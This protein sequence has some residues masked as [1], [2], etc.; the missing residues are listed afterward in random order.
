MLDMS[1]PRIPAQITSKL[2]SEYSSKGS[3]RRR[4]GSGDSTEFCGS[5]V[6]FAHHRSKRSIFKGIR[7]ISRKSHGSNSFIH[8]LGHYFI[9]AHISKVSQN[10]SFLVLQAYNLTFPLRHMHFIPVSFCRVFYHLSR[11]NRWL[12]RHLLL[13][14]TILD[15]GISWAYTLWVNNSRG[16]NYCSS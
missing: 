14:I 13:E 7:K 3:K 11:R 2:I 10:T 5:P 1:E 15:K 4:R 8:P 16:R 9:H 12:I 6:R